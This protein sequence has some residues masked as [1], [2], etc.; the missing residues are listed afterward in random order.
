MLEAFGAYLRSQRVLRG[1]SLE[2]IAN[3]TKIPQRR[4]QA[5]E[6]GDQDEFPDEVFIKGYIR[7]YADTIGA[8]VDEIFV[9]YDEIVAAP[10]RKEVERQKQIE[11]TSARKKKYFVSAAVG[12]VLISGLIAAAL[13]FGPKEAGDLPSPLTGPANNMAVEPVPAGLN[14]GAAIPSP[15]VLA[16][17]EEE[18]LAED[19]EAEPTAVNGSEASPDGADAGLDAIADGIAPVQPNAQEPPERKTVGSGER[20]SDMEK[21]EPVSILSASDMAKQFLSSISENSVT[22]QAHK[23]GL[24]KKAK[25]LRLVIRV[26]EKGWFKLVVDGSDKMDF[27]MPAG[28]SKIFYAASSIKMMIGNKQGTELSLNGQALQLPAS[29]DNVIRNF[30]VTAELLE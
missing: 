5:L 27:I 21:L 7:S 1:I 13:W 11:E 28:A 10:R 16:H 9:A 19:Q 22:I 17:S 6:E 8:D 24:E 26:K 30:L 15:D 23:E 3:V 25:S 2:E 18:V 4:L 29:S 20:D 14:S 12:A